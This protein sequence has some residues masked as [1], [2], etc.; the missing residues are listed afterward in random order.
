MRFSGIDYDDDDAGDKLHA[1]ICRAQGVL[2]RYEGYLLQT[3]MG[4]KGS[5]LYISFGA[6]IA[7]EDDTVRAAAAALEMGDV[8]R[9]LGFLGPLQIGISSGLVHSGAYG[10]LR[11]RTYGVMGNEVNISARLMSVAAPGQILVSPR[12]AAV[13]GDEFSLEPLAP[14]RL[15]GYRRT[16]H[17]VSPVGAGRDGPGRCLGPHRGCDG[18]TRF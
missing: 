17:P 2:A 6:P 13:I 9:S 8:A 16:V 5:Y 1:F 15:K 12:V 3:T 10:S 18:R 11:R 14:I 4:D 7:H